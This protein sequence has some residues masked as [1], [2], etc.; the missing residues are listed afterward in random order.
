DV[1]QPPLLV[2]LGRC[3]RLARGQL[4][5]LEAWDEDGVE[6]Q[7]FRLVKRQ[8]VDAARAPAAGIEAPAQLGDKRGGV[9]FER[10][11]QRD[12]PSEVGLADEL[13]LAEPVR[14]LLEPAGLERRRAYRVGRSAIAALQPAHEPTRRVSIEKRR[15]LEWDR[16]IVQ[17]FLEVRQARVRAAEDRDLLERHLSRADRRDD[18][19]CLGSR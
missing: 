2:E 15:A 5:L 19:R 3:A 4:L 18:G 9:T 16:G 11:R 13:A 14:Q 6:L 10:I 17:R 12:E 7:P 1:E 8:Q